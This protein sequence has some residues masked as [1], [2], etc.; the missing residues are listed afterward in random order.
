MTTGF[1]AGLLVT[2]EE[3]VWDDVFELAAALTAE[4]TA[5]LTVELALELTEELT[6]ETALVLA[7]EE[8]VKSI[9]TGP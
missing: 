8:T 7:K 9:A 3:A 4:L 5:E 2:L 1:G 6:A